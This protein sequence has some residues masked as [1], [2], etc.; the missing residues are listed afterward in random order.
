MSEKKDKVKLLVSGEMRSGTTFLGNFLNTQNNFFVYSDMLV[1]LVR[2]YDKLNISDADDRLSSREK[3]ILFSN[4]IAEARKNN[5]LLDDLPRSEITTWYQLFDLVLNELSKLKE[6][7]LVGVKITKSDLM[8]DNLLKHGYKIIYCVRDPRDVI[9]SA[10]NRFSYFDHGQFIKSWMK[11]VNRALEL[12]LHS[13]FYLLKYEDL[14]LN[15]EKEC[16]K[17]SNFLDLKVTH[18]IEGNLIQ[19]LDSGYINNSSFGDVKKVFDPTAVFRWKNDMESKDNQ[20]TELYLKQELIELGYEL[21]NNKVGLKGRLEFAIQ[22]STF[23]YYLKKV[24]QKIR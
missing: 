10:K 4:V 21:L 24:I 23:N 12:R 6:C 20:M 1:S 17:I 15:P 3:N 22:N 18:D 5:V 2:E 13:N 8:F 11:S 7:K 16:H 9:I 19:G 14:I